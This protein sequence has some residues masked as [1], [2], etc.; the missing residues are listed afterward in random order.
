MKLGGAF[1]W[2]PLKTVEIINQALQKS[3]RV[4]GTKGFNFLSQSAHIEEVVSIIYCFLSV[5]HEKLRKSVYVIDLLNLINNSLFI[6]QDV[7]NPRLFRI[8][9]LKDRELLDFLLSHRGR[10]RDFVREVSGRGCDGSEVRGQKETFMASN[11][12]IQHF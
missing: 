2:I 3:V 12:F 11:N 10:V 8:K 5:I 9:V 4:L 7:L 6:F 1:C